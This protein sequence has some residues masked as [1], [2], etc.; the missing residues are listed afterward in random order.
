MQNIYSRMHAFHIFVKGELRD[1]KFG[2]Q[3]GALKMR[4]YLA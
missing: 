4:D 1:C 3:V 2:V